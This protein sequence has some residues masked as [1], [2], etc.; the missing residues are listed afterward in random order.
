LPL[1]IIIMSSELCA[2]I[3]K[4]GKRRGMAC[5]RKA[6]KIIHD[7]LMQP[8]QPM[9]QKEPMQPMKQKEQNQIVCRHINEKTPIGERVCRLFKELD[10]VDILEAH[11]SGSNPFDFTMTLSDGR[12]IHVDTKAT[13]RKCV[14][15]KE[16]WYKSLQNSAGRHFSLAQKYSK[17]WYE[18]FIASGYMSNMCDMTSFPSYE[19]WEKDVFHSSKSKSDW[20]KKIQCKQPSG[21]SEECNDFAKAFHTCITEEDKTILANQ[22]MDLARHA[23]G[24]KHY[25]IQLLSDLDNDISDVLWSSHALIPS[26]LPRVDIISN[27]DVSLLLTWEDGRSLPLIIHWG[28]KG[29]SHLRMDIK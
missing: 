11:P 17:L 14:T 28:C 7:T 10:G 25:Y 12:E 20:I 13:K 21:F 29:I 24:E 23:L 19:E 6:C 5:G 1:H 9:Q 22:V 15:T 4:S 26:G 3:I 2:A 27:K 8:I 18:R 16:P